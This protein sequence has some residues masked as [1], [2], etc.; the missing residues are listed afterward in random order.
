MRV[1][2]NVTTIRRASSVSN[3]LPSGPNNIILIYSYTSGGSTVNLTNTWAFTVPAYT[4]PIPAAN[5]DTR[6][7]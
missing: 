4:R 5:A 2:N 3:L 6:S 7:R 1:T